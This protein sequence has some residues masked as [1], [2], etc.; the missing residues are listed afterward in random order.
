MSSEELTHRLWE[1]VWRGYAANDSIAVLR[2][3]ILNNFKAS[4]LD[5]GRRFSRRRGFN[6]WAATRPLQG[7]WYL[8][9]QND[10]EDAVEQEELVKERVRL[11]LLRYGVLFRELLQQELPGLR[12]RDIFRTL[13]LMEFSGELYAGYFFAGLSGLQFIGKE[14]YRLLQAGLNE[15]CIYWLNACD[16]LRPAA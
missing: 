10:V 15:D 6:R 12:W 1:H 13:R 14:A 7:N 11:L 8:L 2:M 5:E 3:A 9:P 16:R 4:P